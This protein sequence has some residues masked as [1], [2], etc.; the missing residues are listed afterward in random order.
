[1]N[2]TQ[3]L[4]QGYVYFLEDYTAPKVFNGQYFECL[5][6]NQKIAANASISEDTGL[7]ID[8]FIINKTKKI[9]IMNIYVLEQ[10]VVSSYDTYAS[11]IVIAENEDEARKIHPSPYVTH[12]TN[13]K[14]MGTYSGVSNKGDEYDIGSSGWV[15]YNEIDKLKVTHIGKALDN[16]EKGVVLASF[17]AG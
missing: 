17:N 3:E 9:K 12:I 14:W 1:M 7:T 5:Y 15:E 8:E 2:Y 13:D 10:N 4:K 11:A 16:Q 6:T